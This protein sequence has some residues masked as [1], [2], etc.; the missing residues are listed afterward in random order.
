[1][2]NCFLLPDINA[3][4]QVYTGH[5]LRPKV[6]PIRKVIHIFI[7]I[8]MKSNNQAIFHIIVN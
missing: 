4:E 8:F 2:V 1:M 7:I 5:D 6:I 3:M